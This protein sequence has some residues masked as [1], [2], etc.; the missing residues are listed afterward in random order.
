M[1]SMDDDDLLEYE[2]DI[3]NFGIQT[4]ADLHVKTTNDIL[5]K[6]RTEWWPRA[7]YGRYDITT[8]TYTEMDNNLLTYS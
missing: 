6:L 4:F 5:R 2:P 3:Q 7:T 1:L 8:G